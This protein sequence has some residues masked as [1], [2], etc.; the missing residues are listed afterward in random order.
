ME[1]IAEGIFVETMYE[2]VNVGAI[3]TE[4]GFICIDSPTYPRD[5]RHWA[6]R[7]TQLHKCPVLFIILTDHQGDRVLNTRWLNAP[8]IAH[9]QVTEKLNSYDKR[10]PQLLLDSVALRNPDI[11]RELSAGA[12]ERPTFSFSTQMTLATRPYHVYLLH[13]PGPTPGTVWVH[14]PEAGVLFTG[15]SIVTGTHPPLAEMCCQEWLESLNSLLVGEINAQLIVPGRGDVGG[16]ETA[17][18][19]VDYLSRI[20]HYVQQHYESGQPRD[21]IT[22]Y[23]PELLQRLPVDH[24]PR[25]WVT[26]QIKLGLDRA[27]DEIKSSS[28]DVARARAVMQN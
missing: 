26:R 19:I 28:T 27:Y 8:I 20:R 9:Q 13:R 21:E 6:A 22:I 3:L 24:L 4:K 7:L 5:A 25:D 10:Y 17:S 18:S 16:P 1:E 23:V 15:D 2:G 14:A 12:V 11:T